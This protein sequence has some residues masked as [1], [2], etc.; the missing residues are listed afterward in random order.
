MRNHLSVP[1]SLSRRNN[2]SSGLL[3][4]LSQDVLLEADLYFLMKQL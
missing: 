1:G 2:V 4:F 3:P